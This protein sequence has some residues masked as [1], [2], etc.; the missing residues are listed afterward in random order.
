MS[1]KKFE[2]VERITDK[3][4]LIKEVNNYLKETKY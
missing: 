4:I 1:E 3:E 2:L